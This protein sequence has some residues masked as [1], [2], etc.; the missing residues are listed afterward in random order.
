MTDVLSPDTSAVTRERRVVR[1][2]RTGPVVAIAVAAALAWIA[3][4]NG[5]YALEKRTGLAIVVWWILGVG[6]LVRLW[7]R[8]LPTRATLGVGAL[9]AA[10]AGWTALSIAW[11]HDAE[12]AYDE[13]VRVL[14]YLGVFALAVAFMA[15]VSRR[16]VADGIALAAVAVAVIALTT[17]F[18]PSVVSSGSQYRFLP[19][20]DTRLSFP[21]GYWNALAIFVALACPLLL[22]SA[23]RAASPLARAF[24][25]APFPLL[26]VTVYLASSRGGAVTFAVGIVAFL[27]LARDRLLTLAALAVAGVAS[28]VAVSFVHARSQLVNVPTAPAATG[29]GHAAAFVV[30][31]CAVGAAGVYVLADRFVLPRRPRSERV[32][33]TLLIGIVAVVVIG[34]IASN[35]K[36]RFESFKQ[37]PSAGAT[38]QAS[39]YV[40]AHLLSGSGNGRWQYWTVAADE[41]KAHPLVGGGA[42]S[43]REWWERDRPVGNFA[44]DAHSLYIE[45]LGELGIV[46]F[47]LVVGMLLLGIVAGVRRAWRIPGSGAEAPALAAV[48]IALAVA[49]GVDW[50]WELTAVAV[51]GF[52]ALAALLERDTSEPAP[53]ISAPL[54]WRGVAA[55]VA[56]VVV[57]L[58][59]LPYVAQIRLDESQAAVRR[60]DA[61]TAVDRARSAK[62]L[63]PWAAS[64]YVQLALVYEQAG[65]IE[66]AR[67]AVRD[68][69]DRDSRDWSLWLI[70]SRL[71]TKAGAIDEALRSLE[72]AQRLNPLAPLPSI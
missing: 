22:R 33:R 31:V 64:P 25:V 37:S 54:P 38:V 67:A 45:T 39:D 16:H 34:V 28:A 66:A 9:L 24:A 46:G 14:L 62:D 10:Y 2:R 47:A 50:M 49:L 41:F 71:E 35:P 72:R 53:A 52:V 20:A 11:S 51:I 63:M 7:P 57:V 55:A 23:T 1:R 27:V 58:Q 69:I 42:G 26:T 5:T 60:E 32:D 40:T 43:Y 56:L 8:R 65:Q 6:A 21:V 3:Y 17:R 13:F 59:A 68:A 30:V 61:N 19:V 12:A 44:L 18:F 15:Y 36:Q 70:R 48:V 4:D 29:Q